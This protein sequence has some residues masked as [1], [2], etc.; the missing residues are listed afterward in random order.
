MSLM[1]FLELLVTAD[2]VGVTAFCLWANAR[3]SKPAP[4]RYLNV[5]KESQVLINKAVF[6]S[7]IVTH[8]LYIIAS[9][10]SVWDG[11][12]KVLGFA[13]SLVICYYAL[14]FFNVLCEKPEDQDCQRSL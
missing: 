12:F 9:P 11:L 14:E 7:V 2:M 13:V 10:I 8:T 1:L 5:P 4:E 6:W 3:L